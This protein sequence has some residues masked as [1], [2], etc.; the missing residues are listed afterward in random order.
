MDALPSGEQDF[1]MQMIIE[2]ANIQNPKEFAEHILKQ[3]LECSS[4]VPNDDMTVLVVGIWSL[5]N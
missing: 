4:N 3:V 1:L 2:G 5:E